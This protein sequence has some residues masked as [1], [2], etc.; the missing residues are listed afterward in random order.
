MS[1]LRLGALWALPLILLPIVIHLIHR[2]RHPTVPWAAMMFLERATRSRR[3]GAKLK[4]YLVLATRMLV[5][6][7]VVFAL[8][9]P[10]SSGMFSVAAGRVVSGGTVVVL[11]DRSPSMQR[12]LAN[13]ETRQQNALSNLAK[14]L[15][16]LGVKRCTLI[17]SVSAS[18]IEL[19]S[20]EALMQ[21][22]TVAAADSSADLPHML[23]EGLR[24]LESA[25]RSV[26]DVW[27]CSDRAIHDWD[28]DS[29]VWKE[30]ESLVRQLGRGVRFHLVEFPNDDQVNAS[31][32][33]TGTR[34][35]GQGRGLL[36]SVAVQSESASETMMPVRVSVGGV[37]H[38]VDVP[39]VDGKAELI[40]HAIEISSSDDQVFG[41]VSIEAD[42]NAADD[43]WFFTASAS[44]KRP[45]ALVTATPC[46]ALDVATD[47]VGRLQ[48]DAVDA[49]TPP[50][51]LVDRLATVSSLV[52][53]GPLPSGDEAAA[54]SEFLR[55]GGSV[56]FFPPRDID[57][58]RAFEGVGW[59]QWSRDQAIR[60][61]FDPW[62]FTL[63]ARCGIE[64][65]LVQLASTVDGDLVA[66]KIRVDAGTA[67][68]CGTDVMD[69]DGVFVK[70]G[71]V[72]YG[73]LQE[74]IDS[75]LLQNQIQGSLVASAESQLTLEAEIK[76]ASEASLLISSST[77]NE[78]VASGHQAGV[79][80]IKG[81]SD[82]GPRLVAINRSVGESV[83]AKIDDAKL[84]SLV[85]S[86]SWNRV[87]VGDAQVDSNRGFVREIWGMLWMLVIAGML[88]EAWLTLPAKRTAVIR[89][90]GAAS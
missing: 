68:F 39:L 76:D 41:E 57:D 22:S 31:V 56:V 34:L 2:R 54:I 36:I 40:D 65:Q 80:A 1:F 89:E 69:P 9:R 49:T 67:W 7:A 33:V 13:G 21:A 90:R 3:G 29:A 28:P 14:T 12:R 55:R 62:E 81:D 87:E 61:S 27:V 72:L 83:D 43:Q 84:V 70:N 58:S 47:I 79:L 50:R 52:W 19:R 85:P 24:Y 8:A 75:S 66:G 48:S 5:I 78:F 16:T 10:L 71:L 74:A 35:E 38:S 44:Q 11:L 60:A 86:L 53:Q 6:A 37:T 23:R 20:V 64:G 15:Q 63:D 32:A 18:P 77:Q 45:V 88:V 4:R 46:L 26:A 42:V 25:D 59:N 30:I 73:L 17:D 82:A 51:P